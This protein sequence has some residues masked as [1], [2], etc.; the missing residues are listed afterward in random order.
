M[1]SS[2]GITTDKTSLTL[3]DTVEKAEEQ[4]INQCN[5]RNPDR[6]RDFKLLLLNE[7]LYRLCSKHRHCRG[8]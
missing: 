1:H 6:E 4:N 2:S 7:Q 5:E 3:A 8:Q